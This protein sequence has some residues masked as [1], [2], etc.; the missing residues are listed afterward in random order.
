MV[1]DLQLFARAYAGREPPDLE[2]A[3]AQVRDLAIG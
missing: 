1:R 3:N 2:V